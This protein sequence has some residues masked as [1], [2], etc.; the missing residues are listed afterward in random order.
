MFQQQKASFVESQTIVLK[1]TLYCYGNMVLRAP[2]CLKL[3]VEK[4]NLR[5]K[6]VYFIIQKLNGFF[7]ELVNETVVRRCS[8]KEVFLNILQNWKKKIC[9]GAYFWKICKPEGQQLY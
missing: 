8:R 9:V 1:E 5:N 6:H 3:N 4:F 7:S 2:Y